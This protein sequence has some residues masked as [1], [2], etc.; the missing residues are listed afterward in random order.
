[1][2]I[3]V[4]DKSIYNLISAGEVVERPASVVKELAENSID[5]GATTIEIEIKNGGISSIYVADNGFGIKKEDLKTA[6]LPHAT[7]KIS[8]ADD[9]SSIAT[10]GFRGE[11]LP[12][13][14]SVSKVLID[15]KTLEDDAS[16][17]L[18][19]DGGQVVSTGKSGRSS[20][21]AVTISSLFFN[22]PAR[23]KFLKTERSEQSAITVL[24]QRLIL[25]NPEISWTYIADG[26]QIYYTDGTGLENALHAVF[27]R[28]TVKNFAEMYAESRNFRLNGYIS[29]P[30]ASKPNR[31]YQ[32]VI[33]NGRW[34]ECDLV[35]QAV[36][37]AYA[38]YLM[39]RSYPAFVLEFILPFDMLDVNVHP[40][41]TEVR[42]SDNQAVFGFV[43]KYV[44]ARLSELSAPP[45]FESISSAKGSAANDSNSFL[46]NSTKPEAQVSQANEEH[47]S[48]IDPSKNP[49]VSEYFSSKTPPKP[50]YSNISFLDDLRFGGS[51]KPNPSALNDKPFVDY[52]NKSVQPGYADGMGL[53]LGENSKISSKSTGANEFLNTLTKD[54]YD[55]DN[56]GFGTNP[57]SVISYKQDTFDADD[58][59]A[60]SSSPFFGRAAGQLFSTYLIV[61]DGN[62]AYFIDQHAAH[63]KILYDEL[64]KNLSEGVS[65]P[66]LF[67][68]VAEFN[69]QE[70][71]FVEYISGDLKE[72]GFEIEEFGERTI[73]ISSVPLALTEMNFKKFF[74]MLFEEVGSYKTLRLK[75][76]IKDKLAQTA[77]KAAIKGGD[78][79]NPAQIQALL[80]AFAAAGSPPLTCPHGRP[81]VIKLTKRDIEK[82]FKRIV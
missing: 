66:M 46:D 11:A 58:N 19:L 5:A 4:L 78:A 51:S 9:L 68:Y 57:E 10:L 55:S 69:H 67:P 17:T 59:D 16:N 61:E 54:S 20:G 21:T 6:F 27:D 82:L 40:A 79:L 30:S 56:D 73:K 3:N 42:F 45:S 32:T 41:K 44:S 1:M 8:S 29:A 47:S 53:P 64:V 75:D 18:T 72:L 63:E 31:T 34:V 62:D 26:K 71:D 65:Q 33:V 81:A 24:V 13:I 70:F 60:K 7:S 48:S 43:Y 14:A 38:P 77:C 2:K 35:R 80:D 74:E 28:E 25:S 49:A 36:E 22:T 39:T 52:K 23:L 15:S 76:L 37:K 12:S 50:V